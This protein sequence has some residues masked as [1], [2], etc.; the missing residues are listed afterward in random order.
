MHITNRLFEIEG[1]IYSFGFDFC[2]A[3]KEK[4]NK[5][6]GYF[7]RKMILNLYARWK[8]PKFAGVC[9]WGKGFEI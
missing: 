3:G 6:Y 2:I 9:V 1:N 4:E 5:A 8:A 7:Y